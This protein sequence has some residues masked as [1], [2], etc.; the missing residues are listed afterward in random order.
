[1]KIKDIAFFLEEY[2]PLSLQESYDNSGLLIGSHDN[3]ITKALITLD[4]TDAVM[5]EAIA[6]KCD[7]IIAHH[8]L[9]FKGIKSLTGN[10]YVEKLIVKA[11]K[12]D[13]FI[14]A[15]HTN[16]DNL[17]NGVNGILAEK[18][19]L[20]NAKILSVNNK[21]LKK[22]VTF[23]PVD[24]ADKVRNAMFG[25]GAGHIGNYDNCSYH[26]SGEGTFR[27][28][29][30]SDPFVGKTGDLHFEKELRIETIVPDFNMGKVVH[31][32]LTA[33]PYEE[34]AYDI[35]SLDNP[36]VRIGAGMIGDL[37]EETDP[38]AFLT[39]V[40]SVL[41]SKTIRHSPYIDRKIKKVAICGGSGS[42][43]IHKAF[44]AGADIFITGDITYHDFFNYNGRMIIADAGHY[45]TEQFTKELLHTVLKEN[46]PTFALLISRTVTNPVN[47]I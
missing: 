28:M 7:L 2:A 31:A 23:C 25:A 45:E 33:H 9:I 34:V 8:P 21:G 47:V 38:V 32:M 22:L 24:H 26:V 36:D 27:G 20:A 16:L 14:Y 17:R 44:N 15:I 19:G 12:N 29:E 5:D 39:H 35:Y 30:G 43:L 42:F 18:L 3:I 13:I 37:Q 40:K 41:N 11:I 4:V 46:F 6:E 1:M 10:N